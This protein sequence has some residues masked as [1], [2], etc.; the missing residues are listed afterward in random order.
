MLVVVVVVLV[1]VVRLVE[2][3]LICEL[4]PEFEFELVLCDNL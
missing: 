1:L 3:E 2:A 4:V